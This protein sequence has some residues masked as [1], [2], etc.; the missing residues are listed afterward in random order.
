MS[1]SIISPD[2]DWLSFNIFSTFDIENFAALPVDELILL[3]LENLEPS[4]V[5]APDL[6][7]VGLARTLDIPRLVVVSGSDGKRLLVEVPNLCSS[8]IW[9][10]NDHVSIVDQV[11]ISVVWQGRNDV[12]VSFNIEAELFVELTLS[13]FLLV[14]INIDDS[15]SL[16]NLSVLGFHDK[17]SVLVIKSTVNSHDITLLDVNNHIVLVSE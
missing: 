3:I 16:V 9:N 8:S 2:T 13:W 11:K 6:H 1:S 14:L 5:G 17:V 15:P 10:L 4:R 7:I 12:E